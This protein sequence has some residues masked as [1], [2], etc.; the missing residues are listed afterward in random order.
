MVWLCLCYGDAYGY[1]YAYNYGHSSGYGHCYGYVIVTAMDTAIVIAIVIVITA[2]KHAYRDKA[3]TTYVNMFGI[4]G[5]GQ[6]WPNITKYTCSKHILE[7]LNLPSISNRKQSTTRVI[8]VRESHLF[9]Q[10]VYISFSKSQGARSDAK[11]HFQP[12]AWRIPNG[13]MQVAI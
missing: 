10:L 4:W 2:T 3:M 6:S 8:Q 1:G 11:T 13:G 7:Q 9:L 5:M 12:G